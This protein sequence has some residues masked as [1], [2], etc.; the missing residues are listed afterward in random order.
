MP[1]KRG[2]SDF[3]RRCPRVFFLLLCVGLVCW[4]SLAFTSSCFAG[5]ASLTALERE[6]HAL[7]NEH[8]RAIGLRPL[9]YDGEIVRHARRHS[10]EMARGRGGVDHLG[11]EERRAALSRRIEFN[12]FAENVA[13]NNWVASRTAEVAVRGW[14]KSAGHR[15]N[16]E[17]GFTLT[18]VGVARSETGSYFFTQIFLATPSARSPRHK[19][20]R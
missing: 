7:V 15:R 17:G 10:Q 4:G 6:V 16:M 19:G 8:R 2:S 12:G 18:G 11:A 9:A 13:M 14:R 20:S 1:S 3:V 5:E